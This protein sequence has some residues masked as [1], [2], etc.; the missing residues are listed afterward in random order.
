MNYLNNLLTLN[1]L[2]SGLPP[3]ISS[4][5]NFRVI[6]GTTQ[7]ENPREND[8]WIETNTTITSYSFQNFD[9]R[10]DLDFIEGKIYIKTDLN[11]NYIFNAIKI[12]E[13]YVS[14]VT[15]YQIESNDGILVCNR[16]MASIYK[17]NKW[18]LLATFWYNR[19]NF[20]TINTFNRGT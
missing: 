12:N 17:N 15:V 11:T 20:Y 10:N 13:L 18:N 6:G 19:G 7:P 3:I 9:S 16:K 4:D 14:P 5:L 1:C 8:I 2:G